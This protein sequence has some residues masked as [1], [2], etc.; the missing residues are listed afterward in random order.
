MKRNEQIAY[1]RGYRVDSDGN[2]FKN[3]KLV[4]T[5]KNDQGYLLFGTGSKIKGTFVNVTVHRLVAYQKYKEKMYDHRV[6]RHMDGDKLNNSFKNI[7]IGSYSDNYKDISKKDR[8]LIIKKMAITK[9]GLSKMQIDKIFE[10]KQ[11]GVL[12]NEISK[13]LGIS[14]SWISMIVNK[15]TGYSKYL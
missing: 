13:R 10:L 14:K 9:Q 3:G 12:Q 2:L 5:S 7:S 6:V 4:I 15:K 1:E 11:N 8:F